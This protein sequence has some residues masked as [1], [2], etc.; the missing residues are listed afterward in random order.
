MLKREA[1][2]ERVNVQIIRYKE[3]KEKPNKWSGKKREKVL[4]MLSERQKWVGMT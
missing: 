1:E 4:V 3:E 2:R